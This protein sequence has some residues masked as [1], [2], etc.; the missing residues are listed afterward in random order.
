MIENE[1][2][3]VIFVLIVIK[4]EIKMILSTCFLF[5]FNLN[6]FFLIQIMSFRTFKQKKRRNSHL[7]LMGQ[8]LIY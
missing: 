7:N 4:R 5:F 8:I 6:R 3:S 1:K 2:R